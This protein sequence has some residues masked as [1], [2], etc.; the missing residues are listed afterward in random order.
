MTC[1][2]VANLRFL[3]PL[4]LRST[5]CG[6]PS[7]LLSANE[8]GVDG[9]EVF[10]KFLLFR[11]DLIG[12]C[13]CVYHVDLGREQ[14]ENMLE[15]FEGETT[16]P[17]SVGNGNRLDK[18]LARVVQ[19]RLETFALPVDAAG[20]I[21]DE[22]VVWE[23]GAECIDLSIKIGLMLGAGDAGI[24]V[25]VSAAACRFGFFCLDITLRESGRG[26]IIFFP[27]QSVH[28]QEHGCGDIVNPPSPKGEGR[29]DLPRPRPTSQSATTDAQFL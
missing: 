16:Q 21:G 7:S 25:M 6:C 23:C 11:S 1:G 26:R 12:C 15:Q 5:R 24:D 3:L 13:R 20:N 18:P 4:P 29:F 10:C 17:V 14:A 8:D 2:F 22:D 28:T 27:L 19:K 9:H